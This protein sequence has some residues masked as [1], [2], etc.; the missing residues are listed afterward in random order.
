M[1]E[2]PTLASR[3]GYPFLPWARWT[4]IVTVAIPLNDPRIAL[5]LMLLAAMPPLA[6]A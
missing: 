6:T 3:T 4:S 5:Q 1:T 2:F